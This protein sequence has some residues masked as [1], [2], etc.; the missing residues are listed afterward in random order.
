MRFRRFRNRFTRGDG[1]P[2]QIRTCQCGRF[3]SVSE[4]N[5][6][7]T[8]IHELPWCARFETLMR[9]IEGQAGVALHGGVVTVDDLESKAN[10]EMVIIADGDTA[11]DVQG[12][13]KFTDEKA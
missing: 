6:R 1:D 7:Q 10:P 9:E 5:G 13:I 11:A 3:V 8:A 2:A 12:G 4:A